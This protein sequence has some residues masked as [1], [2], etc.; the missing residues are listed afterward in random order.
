MRRWIVGGGQLSVWSLPAQ[1]SGRGSAMWILIVAWLTGHPILPHHQAPPAQRACSP[2]HVRPLPT[3]SRARGLPAPLPHRKIREAGQPHICIPVGIA[4]R[5]RRQAAGCIHRD[6]PQRSTCWPWGRNRELI[7]PGVAGR[8][9]QVGDLVTSVSCAMTPALQDRS[10]LTGCGLGWQIYASPPPV[11]GRL[12]AR[13]RPQR[14][15]G[16]WRVAI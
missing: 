13:S 7:T 2:A 10:C 3:I 15:L 11:D 8:S 9:R 16:G 6:R 4:C 12:S 1:G 5:C 14:V